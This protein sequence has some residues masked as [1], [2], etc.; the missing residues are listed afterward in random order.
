MSE[1]LTGHSTAAHRPPAFSHTLEA[2]GHH[3]RRRALTTLQINVGRHCNQSCRHCHVGAGPTRPE[4]MTRETAE[5]LIGLL[6]GPGGDG[7]HTV[8][9]T[10]GAPELNPNFRTLVEASRRLDRHVIDRCNLTVLL[11]P[12]QEDTAAFLAAHGVEIIA[13]LPCYTRENVDRQRGPGV[14]DRSLEALRRLNALGYGHPDTGRVL[15]LVYN[16]G[17]AFLPAAQCA[18]EAD[19]RAHL[20]EESGIE[21]NVLLTLTN[22]P[23]RRFRRQL[24][25]AGGLDDYMRLLHDRF[26]DDTVD[27]LMCRNLVSV[28]WDGGLFDCDFNQAVDLPVPGTARTIWEIS[29]LRELDDAP[30]AVG[31]HCYSCTAG[32]GSS[33]GGALAG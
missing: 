1:N 21:F 27:G 9:I 6:E 19:Y 23:I 12:G 10:G 29:S 22:A 8:D 16:P 30:I 5:R 2:R 32:A 18:L 7:I 11:E 25:Q 13:S 4:E 33:C 24:L 28:S 26:N 14:F 3:L 31:D 17:G 15:K 20:R